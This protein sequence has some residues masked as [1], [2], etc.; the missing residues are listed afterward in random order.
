[1]KHRV[2]CIS[3]IVRVTAV[4]SYGLCAFLSALWFCPLNSS[5]R[6][7]LHL[8]APALTP[9]PAQDA[10]AVTASAHKHNTIEGEKTESHPLVKLL[11]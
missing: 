10:L 6:P 3:C 7:A 1:M 5:G 2:T 8:A 4:F 11:H 9:P